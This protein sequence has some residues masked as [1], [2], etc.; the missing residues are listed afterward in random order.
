MNTTF[1]PV[2][3]GLVIGVLIPIDV[4]RDVCA[5]TSACA[6]CKPELRPAEEFAAGASPVPALPLLP[7]LL[8]PAAITAMMGSTDRAARR[9][10]LG[11]GLDMDRVRN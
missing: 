8:Q 2:G 7:L 11:L 5:E 6:S 10:T 9:L 1:L 4:G 3:M